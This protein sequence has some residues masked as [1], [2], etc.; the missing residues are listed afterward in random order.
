MRDLDATTRRYET[1]LGAIVETHESLPDQGVSA[2]AL[3]LGDSGRVEL[4][5]PTALDTPVGRFLARNGE[6]MHH[7]AYC[8][9]S[10]EA[11]LAQLRA[12]GATL[13]DE[14]PRDGLYGRV[15]F[16]HHESLSG[17]LTEL[18]EPHHGKGPHG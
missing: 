13:I 16:I 8:V 11:E 15:A 4:L 9:D 6:G 18:V 14:V 5:A 1:Q 2:V 7:L 17:V 3:R 10:I 12:R